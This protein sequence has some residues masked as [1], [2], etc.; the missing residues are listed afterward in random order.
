MRTCKWCGKLY[1]EMKHP[2]ANYHGCCSTRCMNA[3]DKSKQQE[4][5]RKYKK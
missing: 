2:G 4:R 1:D 3:L 5:D